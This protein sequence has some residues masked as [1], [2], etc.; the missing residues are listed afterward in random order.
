M[1]NNQRKKK[2]SIHIELSIL[3]LLG[4]GV[5]IFI[6]LLWMF[7]LG[8]WAGQT[9]L[10]PEGGDAPAESTGLP[11]ESRAPAP[12]SAAKAA[13]DKPI[14]PIEPIVPGE[15][16][17]ADEPT[18]PDGPTEPVEPGEDTE[19]VEPPPLES[20][21]AVEPTAPTPGAPETT[22]APPVDEAPAPGHGQASFFSLQV[23]AFSEAERAAKEAAAWR[24]RGV[25]AFALPPEAGGDGLYRVCVG[26]FAE[27]S[28]AN[29]EA[30]RL[31]EAENI[32]TFITLI[33]AP[34]AR[35]P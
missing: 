29:Q 6:V 5:V 20:P 9:V 18:L 21:P 34:K 17:E 3:G 4:L 30:S 19:A 32:K 8:I 33:P 22:P 7:L 25:E 27:L 16:A 11:P 23:A 13:P 14:Q 15:P 12:P 26:R 24:S 35:Q 1:A 10:L 2:K 31:E 28:K